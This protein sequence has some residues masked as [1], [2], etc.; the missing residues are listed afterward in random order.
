MRLTRRFISIL[1]DEQICK[2]AEKYIKPVDKLLNKKFNIKRNDIELYGDYK[3]KLKP[4]YIQSLNNNTNG[5]LVLVSA[6][7]PT[8]YGE[9]KTCT[10]IGLLDGL[11]KIGKNAIA[12]LREP[13][14]G[15]VFGMKGGATGGGN[16]QIVP[17]DEINLHFT[18]DLHAITTAHNLL[19]AMIDN[20]IY[21]GNKLQFDTNTIT[22]PRVVDMNDRSLRNTITG[23]REKSIRETS[24][25][26]T[27]ASEVMAIFCLSNSLEELNTRLGNIIVGYTY[28]KKEITAKDL[29]ANNSM[30]ALLKTAFMPNIVQTLEQNPVI[31]HGGPF[32]NIAHGCSSIISTK[33]AMKM[34]DYVVT[35]AGFGSDLGAEK[36]FNIKSRQFELK[37]DVV[38]IVATV[39]ALKYHGG[40]KKNKAKM[41]STYN[42]E[43]IKRGFEN[44]TTHIENMKKFN[45]PVIVAIN[46]FRLDTNM[47]LN[48]IKQKCENMDVPAIIAEHHY[49][50]GVGARELAKKVVDITKDKRNEDFQYLYSSQMNLYDKIH[51]VSTEIYRASNVVFSRIALRKIKELINTKYNLYPVCIAKTQYSFSDNPQNRG[52]IVNHTINVKDIRLAAGAKF[53][54]VY[55]GDIMTMPGLPRVPAAE[56]IGIDRN[57]EIYGLF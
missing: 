6:L 37:P 57:N 41:E 51:T 1:S 36:F 34:A 29:N 55:L 10:S 33:T 24:Y 4:K 54:I 38:V 45:I 48:F 32:A 35:E 56:N 2:K 28:D 43:Y 8:K 31:I 30:T 12:S 50:G 21:W 52:L 49:R 16:A 47:D 14:L 15:P 23:L 20:H 25:D 46:R 39:R 27:V 5:K 3:C 11:C 44:L 19:S 9:G 26:I 40:F 7:T 42:Q 53:I 18:G 17:M 22:W 13:S